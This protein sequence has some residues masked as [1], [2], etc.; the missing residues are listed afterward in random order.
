MFEPYLTKN[1]YLGKE[2]KHSYPGISAN[3]M[4]QPLIP[5][6]IIIG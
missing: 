2:L 6:L 4:N 1:K 3:P 5:P